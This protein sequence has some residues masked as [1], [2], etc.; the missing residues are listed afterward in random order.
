MENKIS[1][2]VKGFR[3]SHGTQHSLIVML[4]KWKKEL[5]K[6]ENMS[7]IFMD[8]S[9]AFDA[10]NHDLLL[11]KLKAYGF[12]KHALSFMCSYLKNRRQRVQINN[13]FS[14]LKEVIAGVP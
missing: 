3:K 6:E 11:A 2:Y 14:S 1:K 12:S 5:D 10:I 4:E 13:K 8:L 7:A 9:K